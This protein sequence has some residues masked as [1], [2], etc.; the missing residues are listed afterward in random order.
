MVVGE[1]WP[2]VNCVLTAASNPL[3]LNLNYYLSGAI[4]PPVMG[5]KFKNEL[6]I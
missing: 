1:K 5:P 2:R 3:K 4:Y 6:D